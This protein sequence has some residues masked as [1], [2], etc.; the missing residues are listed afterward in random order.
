MLLGD[1]CT[2]L[3]VRKDLTPEE[4]QTFEAVRRKES[5]ATK[6]LRESMKRLPPKFEE[7]LKD[8]PQTHWHTPENSAKWQATYKAMRESPDY[9]RHMEEYQRPQ[10][11]W[12]STWNDADEETARGRPRRAPWLCLAVPPEIGCTCRSQYSCGVN[13]PV[14]CGPVPRGQPSAT[15][16]PRPHKRLPSYAFP[17]NTP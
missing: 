16:S 13:R 5:E 14:P 15:V 7:D 4:R 17:P 2:Y 3:H 9:K 10:K 12:L 8:V 1:F 11:E 6:F